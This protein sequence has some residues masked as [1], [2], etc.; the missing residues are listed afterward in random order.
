MLAFIGG[1]ISLQ[2]V[3]YIG[4]IANA[5]MAIPNLVALVLL[6]GI[7]GKVTKDFFDKYKR[8]EDFDKANQG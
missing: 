5:L 4:D 7:V 6:S 2:L 1:V 8:I 3:F